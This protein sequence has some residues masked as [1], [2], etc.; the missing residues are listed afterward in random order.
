[1]KRIATIIMT[2]IMATVISITAFAGEWKVDQ[3]GWWYDNG[4]GTW[5]ANCWQWIDQ[6]GDGTAECYYFNQQGYCLLNTVTPDGYTVNADGAWTING[7]LQTKFVGQYTV[8]N[9]NTEDTDEEKVE[10]LMLY[11]T[12]PILSNDLKKANSGTTNKEN[13]TWAKVIG[14]PYTDSFAEFY[15]G[16]KYN[17][18]R[19]TVAP[20]KA[21]DW[22]KEN[23]RLFQVL[24][25]DDEV[26]YESDEI[27]YKTDMFD[28]DVDISGHD[29]V[30]IYIQGDGYSYEYR[31]IMFKRARFE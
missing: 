4:N 27:N 12:E 20:S 22:G 16:G 30:A 14:L 24:G 26:L 9:T 13:K 28:I 1:M 15:A 11:D 17:H 21:G 25:D 31:P 2:G 8:K 3:N 10:A 6:N 18:F 29:T 23:Y 7:I 19:A 5:P